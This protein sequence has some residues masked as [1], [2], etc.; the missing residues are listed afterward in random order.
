MVF[1][2]IRHDQIAEIENQIP[3]AAISHR[4]KMPR[5]QPV[6]HGQPHTIEWNLQAF[7][8]LPAMGVR[9]EEI[10]API[11]CE[12]LEIFEIADKHVVSC[13]TSEDRRRG[14]GH[15]DGN[16]SAYLMQHAADIEQQ[17]GFRADRQ[18]AATD[19]KMSIEHRINELTPLPPVFHRNRLA[20]N[21]TEEHDEVVIGREPAKTIE[22]PVGNTG[23]FLHRYR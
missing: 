7:G 5:A 19:V 11:L 21:L 13:D 15:R 6:K 18:L 23:F 16:L 14:G 4:N 12:G 9:N 17:V 2:G 1:F 20:A 10:A 3:R 8:G 22:E